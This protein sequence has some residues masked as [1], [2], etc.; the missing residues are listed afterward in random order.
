MQ[1]FGVSFFEST[2]ELPTTPEV[3]WAFVVEHG[4]EIEPLSF[5]PQGVQAVGTL[6]RL[7]GKV[8][9]VIRISGVSRTV[10]WD[11][12]TRCVFASVKPSWPIRTLITEDFAP[13]GTGTRHSIRYEIT[14]RGPIGHL[15][16]PIVC[17]L[18]KRSRKLYQERLRAA[19]AS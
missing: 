19:L 17:R 16:A 8:L 12:P 6:N 1:C 14:P 2:V 7:S 15:A 18:M 13:T 10:V 9:G 5:E 11:P 4:R 3:S